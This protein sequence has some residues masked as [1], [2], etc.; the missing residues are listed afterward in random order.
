MTGPDLCRV[1]DRLPDGFAA[2]AAQAEAEGFAH[3]RRL[4]VDWA[5][6]VLRFDG[7]GEVLLSA[8]SGGRLVGIGGLTRDPDVSGA[9]RMRRFHVLPGLRGQGIGT[10]LA[11]RLMADASAP[12]TVNPGNPAAARFWESLGFE[13]HGDGPPSHRH[14]PIAARGESR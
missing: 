4:A 9:L 5:S 2:L 1:R 13:R 12:L 6:G 3:M 8:W 11:L 10:A 14:A 7:S